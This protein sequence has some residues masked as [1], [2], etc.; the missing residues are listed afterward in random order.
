MASRLEEIRSTRIEK[1]RKLQA[2]GIEP[3]PAQS[4]KDAHNGAVAADFDAYDGT[5][6]SLAGRVRSIRTHGKIAF[7]DLE[8]QS[9]EIQLLLRDS[10]L[11]GTDKKLQTIGFE[12]L[13]LIDTGDFIQAKGL[14]CK[15]K[16]GAV[17]LDVSELKLLTK[18]LRPL[19][20]SWEG[21]K[22][23]EIVFRRRYLD[24]ILNPAHRELFVR[25]SKFWAVNRQFMLS[26]GFIEVE[27]PVLEHVTGGADAR[28]FKTHHNALD[29]DFYLRISTELYQKRLIG[30][31]YEKIFTVG[32]NFRNE[33]ID[34]EHLQEFYQIEWYWAYADYRDNMEMVREMFRYIAQEV[35]GKTKFTKGK[36]TFDLAD[37]WEEVDYA[38]V[39]SEKLGVDIFADSDE[40][41]A[42]AL[43]AKGVRLDGG[44]NR[45]R[46]VDNLWK[47]IRK[48][49][50]GPAFLVN[51]PVF[52]SPLAKSKQEDK[53]LTERFHVILAGSELGNG[54]S[55]L[56]DPMDQLS[57]FREQQAARD[58]GDDES[59]M[60]DIDFVEMLEFGM[61]PTS[62]YAH[63][64]RLFWFLE[65]VTAREGT[66]FPQTRR[67]IEELTRRIYN[68][69]DESRK[70]SGKGSVKVPSGTV[71]ED[72]K[73][74]FPGMFYAFTVIKGVDIRKSDKKLKELT[75][76][77][78][79]AHTH[80][81]EA[82]GD[83]QP[84]AEYRKLFKAT[85]AWKKSRRPSPEAL[86]RRLATGKGIYNVNTAVDAYN[87]AVIETGV[88]LGGFDA[89]HLSFPVTLRLTEK[90][91]KMHLLG[92][93]APT[94]VDAGEIAY[95][96]A[97]KL[98]TLD[99]NY[100]DID[101]TKI[102]EKT[103]EIILYADGA[104]GLS[105]DEVAEALRKGAEYIVRFCG[106][107]IGGI[108]V[109]R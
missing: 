81:L 47:I 28:P 45:A 93:D 56:N 74:K 98:I 59:Q 11:A 30:A 18:S 94:V 77:I 49:I 107:T 78:V 71:A 34:D 92:D 109:V 83:I 27:T 100:R 23:P 12:N 76:K 19:P 104:P 91:E 80:D 16:T 36:H 1:L 52:V 50:A 5:E 31:G 21:L 102:T 88:G 54:Y 105:E 9:G 67:H 46:L 32:P 26:R 68:L 15:S 38:G 41:L 6:L 64:E 106:G 90:G 2:L 48:D 10:R 66:L 62:G 33:G 60:M 61:P 103:K 4:Q 29:E 8:D 96:D 13:D 65:N 87:L 101:A 20:D 84:I 37:D 51:E 79:K 86:L 22:D 3:Y 58:A 85:G 25:K 7:A 39:I 14:V 70:K 89:A 43:I 99:L 35:Y 44:I 97:D 17:S 73:E 55:E 53:R 82:I 75:E 63:S 108:E 40:K 42:K 57:R 95:A 69:P 72:V 24:L